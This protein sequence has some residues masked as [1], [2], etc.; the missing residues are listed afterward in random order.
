MSR[1]AAKIRCNYYPL[2]DPEANLISSCLVFPDQ[3]LS[4]LDPCAGDAGR[5]W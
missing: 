4:V 2:P 3:G 1:F 5:L